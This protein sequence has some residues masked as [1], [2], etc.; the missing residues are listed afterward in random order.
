M[1]AEYFATR[2]CFLQLENK[3]ALHF[4]HPTTTPS[5]PFPEYTSFVFYVWLS[6][7]VV[8]ESITDVSLVDIHV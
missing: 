1:F 6:S 5:L 2:G 3:N 7:T 4:V 8:R